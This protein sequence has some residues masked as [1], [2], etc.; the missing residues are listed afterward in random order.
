MLDPPPPTE[1]FEIKGG[2]KL[3][4]F[5]PGRS[6][7]SFHGESVFLLQE[8]LWSFPVPD[9][10]D[11]RR[12]EI[13]WQ[14][15][16]PLPFRVREGQSMTST[17]EGLAFFGG[18]EDV[19]SF[20]SDLWVYAGGRWECLQC[21]VPA[22]SH[23]AAVWDP[24]G[25]LVISGGKRKEGNASDLYLVDLAKGETT[26]VRVPDMPA[27]A[28]HS[29]N[30]LGHDDFCLFGGCVTNE[31]GKDESNTTIYRL[32][33]VKCKLA[34]VETEFQN[35]GFESHGA[36]CL[37]ER[38]IVFGGLTP[39]KQHRL[40][41]LFDFQHRLWVP[42]DI[43]CDISPIFIFSSQKTTQP[44]AVHILDEKFGQLLILSIFSEPPPDDPSN[45][46]QFIHFLKQSL[47][48]AI[49]YFNTLQSENHDLYVHAKDTAA[50]ARE[51]L[52]PLLVKAGLL[53][54]AQAKKF[55]TLQRDLGKAT[56]VLRLAEKVKRSM[57]SLPP[58]P[59]PEPVLT[60][61]PVIPRER[62]SV[63]QIVGDLR[64]TRSRLRKEIATLDVEAQRISSEIECATF[65]S[66][67]ADFPADFAGKP[68]PI[69]RLEQTQESSR[70]LAREITFLRE[71]LESKRAKV[72]SIHKPKKETVLYIR[73]QLWEATN[74]QTE[75]ARELNQTTRQLYE[76]LARLTQ[77]RNTE[78]LIPDGDA[79]KSAT[80]LIV[81]PVTEQKMQRSLARLRELREQFTVAIDGLDST[82]SAQREGSP[83]K[84]LEQ[85]QIALKE[86]QQWSAEAKGRGR[87]P[88]VRIQLAAPADGRGLDQAKQPELFSTFT[89]IM[90]STAAFLDDVEKVLTQ[91][92]ETLHRSLRDRRT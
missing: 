35:V 32:D 45:H 51:Q 60:E 33:I 7:L 23:H 27:I 80:Q 92:D 71:Q 10:A 63:H 59:L 47:V 69:N 86:M 19:T 68:K 78:L 90:G 9:R 54:D 31:E 38:F 73:H 2:T 26:Q 82:I 17:P 16:L 88:S 30:R 24:R 72:G 50:D 58:K 79:R 46:P 81:C 85:V 76:E 5:E 14:P 74:R 34:K 52:R 41:W 83:A 75:L 64:E 56:E 89:D 62:L 25:F 6:T 4:P 29:I 65:T 28:T 1:K 87:R 20:H 66:L 3:R 55:F 8:G 40:A 91:I 77:L 39:P 84:K 42:L 37:Y 43:P 44:K 11:G 36:C 57:E 22:R 70:Q 15:V 67:T 61:A 13:S 49:E 53:S 18:R 48:V 12:P 21:E